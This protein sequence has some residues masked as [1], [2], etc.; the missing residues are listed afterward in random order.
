M[1]GVMPWGEM[2]DYGSCAPFISFDVLKYCFGNDIAFFVLVLGI[3][4]VVFPIATSV[5]GFWY[6]GVRM[7]YAMGR[8][9]FLPKSF[10]KTNRHNQPILP[11]ILILVV[12]VGFLAMKE[13]RSF[14]TMAFACAFVT[15]NNQLFESR[16]KTPRMEQTLQMLKNLKAVHYCMV[17]ISFFCTIESSTTWIGFAGY[18]T[19]GFILWM[20]M[21][22]TKW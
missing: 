13:I 17:A 22:F 8:Q 3:V 10:S 14:V 2:T 4:G 18:I 6:S 12:S 7:F 20:I 1:A 16:Q 11:N 5:L 15:C 9:N 21:I 19:I